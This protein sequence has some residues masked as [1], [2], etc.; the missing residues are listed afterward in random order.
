MTDVEKGYDIQSSPKPGTM[1]DGGEQTPLSHPSIWLLLAVSMP[2]MAINMA[3]SA[4][5][6]AL[7]SYLSTML[8]NFAVQVTQF[9]GCGLYSRAQRC[10][11]ECSLSHTST[12][13]GSGPLGLL[14]RRSE[15][16]SRDRGDRSSVE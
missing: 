13:L 15:A 4:Q 2:R 1:K 16:K 14:T 11:P 5:W 8:P 7:G 12:C 10:V 3:W 9:I 6:A